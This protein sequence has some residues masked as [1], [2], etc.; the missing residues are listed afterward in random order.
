MDKIKERVLVTGGSGFI[1]SFLVETLLQR[2]ADVHCLLKPGDPAHNLASIRGEIQV[3]RA[4][5]NNLDVVQLVARDARPEVVFHLAAAGVT[6]VHID[7]ALVSRV[8]IEGTLNLLKALAG[9]YRV[10]VNTGTC[11]EYGSNEPP[12]REDQVPRP[13]LPYAIA[14]T[15]VWHFCNHFYQTRN[16]P[17]VTVRPF[18]VYGP[19]QAPNTFIQ[20]CI[21]SAK[22]GT[23]FEMT[24]GEQQRDFVYVTDIVEG[25]IRA[26]SVPQAVGGTFNLCSGHGAALYQVAQMIVAEMGHPIAIKRGALP[27]REGE[28]W[29]LVG[30]TGRARSI[31]GWTPH[32]SL[33]QGIQQTIEA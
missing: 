23:D 2:G 5:L 4:D 6:N 10:F 24:P 1:G 16:W 25:F 7:P 32:V 14:K 27:Y 8:N 13:E 33:Q 29:E 12:L 11:H 17:I 9:S 20:A 19:R 21:R 18:A 22:S 31:L 28:I 3:Y 15:A 30:D 26:A